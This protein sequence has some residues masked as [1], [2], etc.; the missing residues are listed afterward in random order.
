MNLSDSKI[1][2]KI[3]RRNFFYYLGAA[4]A[5]AFLFSKFPFR[6]FNR[7]SGVHSSLNVKENPLAVKRTDPRGKGPVNG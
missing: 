2:N 4:A 6:L 1:T 5:G 3:K 7:K